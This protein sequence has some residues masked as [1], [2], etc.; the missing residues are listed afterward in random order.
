MNSIDLINLK[1]LTGR[2]TMG[3]L[4]DKDINSV[5]D[6][7][8]FEDYIISAYTVQRVTEENNEPPHYYLDS[9]VSAEKVYEMF[10]EEI[11]ERAP[12][13]ELIND[14]DH[15]IEWGVKFL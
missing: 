11:H 4:W 14:H 7:A 10:E 12:V 8:S 5:L 13:S 2:F 15:S 6:R 9:C 1:N 3:Q